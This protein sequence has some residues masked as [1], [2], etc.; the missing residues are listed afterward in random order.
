M[1]ES[2]ECDDVDKIFEAPGSEAD[3][4]Y[5]YFNQP[6]EQIPGY[7]EDKP[8]ILAHR[9]NCGLQ[10]VT[11]DKCLP[12]VTCLKLESEELFIERRSI[13]IIKDFEIDNNEECPN[14]EV[15]ECEEEEEL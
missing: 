1:A 2:S 4:K 15:T 5:R 9:P 13:V 14:I 7:K 10:W 6:I 12:V 11:L 8:Q 3:K